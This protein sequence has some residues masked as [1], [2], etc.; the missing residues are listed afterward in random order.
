MHVAVF[1]FLN[2]PV[3][4]GTGMAFTSISLKIQAAGQPQDTAHFVT[5][6]SFI[7]V[8]RQSLGVAVG[9]V[10]FQNQIQKK[11]NKYLLLAPF[12][13]EYSKD[14]TVLVSLIQGIEAG[15]EKL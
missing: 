7:R 10:I 1:I 5:F 12:T 9:G 2:V 14:A 6:Y 8:L 11:L 3:A 15:I 13:K 4:I